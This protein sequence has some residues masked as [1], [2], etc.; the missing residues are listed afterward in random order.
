VKAKGELPPLAVAKILNALFRAAVATCHFVAP[1]P[2]LLRLITHSRR[3]QKS[4]KT[5]RLHHESRCRPMLRTEGKSMVA[6][7]GLHPLAHRC[8]DC[9]ETR[10]FYGEGV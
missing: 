2:S 9:E 8:R 4:M 10:R 5:I 1:A 7:H 6:I 3:V